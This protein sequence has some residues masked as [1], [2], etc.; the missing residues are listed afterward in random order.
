MTKV[1]HASTKSGAPG[2]SPVDDPIF[3]AIER[4]R[5]AEREYGDVLTVTAKLEQELPH[6]L[7]QSNIDVSGEHI[8]ETDDPRW[9]AHERESWAA[10]E[11]TVECSE[12]LIETRPNTIEGLS[13]L[14]RY[15]SDFMG[16]DYDVSRGILQNAAEALEALTPGAPA[17]DKHPGASKFGNAYREWFEALAI[18]AKLNGG[19]YAA[20]E[21]P[22]GA[23]DAVLDRL[24]T[25]EHQLAFTP[26]A[27]PYQLINKF[28]VL[29]TM[30]CRRERDG[31]PSD[32]RHMIML[33]SVKADLYRFR[34]EQRED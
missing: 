12:A 4:H 16:D 8:V 17:E 25:A 7:R 33:S 13:A 11:K 5:I 9:I 2:A 34:I 31:R 22:D 29:E 6:H 14:V 1:E 15:A 30:I 18:E 24:R 26:A 28:E 19:G 32:S 10:C 23:I 3:A 27:F 20:A 21:D